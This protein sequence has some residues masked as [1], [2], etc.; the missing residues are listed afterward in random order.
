MGV[1]GHWYLELEKEGFW[2]GSPH[3]WVNRYIMSGSQ[4]GN[5]DTQSVIT[6]LVQIEQQIFPFTPAGQGVGHVEARAYPSGSGPPY[7]VVT[8]KTATGPAGST[9]FGNNPQGDLG[10]QWAPTLET[11]VLLN[12]P[13]AG[14]NS[15]GKPISL[16]KYYR[17]LMDGETEDNAVGGITAARKAAMEA[18]V[19]PFKTGLG[20]NSY[21]VIAGSGAQASA[22]PTVQPFLVAHQ[23]PRGKKRKKTGSTGLLGLAA[24]A[25]S[26]ARDAAA[27][28]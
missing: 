15:R 23:I 18:V 3:T 27:L 17:G 13:V 25:A 26:L 22:A 16:R 2:R 10:F 19:L 20:T 21:V 7:L 6:Q 1:N 24:E 14:L 5:T 4:P 28:A 12:T 8:Y 11:C 9:G